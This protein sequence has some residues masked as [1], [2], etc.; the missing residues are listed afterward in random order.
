[1]I[2]KKIALFAF[3]FAALLAQITQAQTLVHYWNFN[4]NSSVGTLLTPN[5]TLVSGASIAAIPGGIS[6]IDLGGTGQGFSNENLNARNGDPAGTHLRFNDPIGGALEFC[7]P[8]TGFTNVV[9]KFST[10][11]SGSGAGLQYWHYST[12]GVNFEPFDTIAPNNGDPTLQ[13]LDFSEVA[14]VDDN[15]DFK[16]RV[17]FAQGGGGTVGNNRFDNFTLDA[18]Q[19]G[20]DVLPP[21]VAFFPLDNATLVP[22]N[23]NPTITFNEPVRLLNNTPLDNTNAASGISLRLDNESGA[24]VPFTTTVSGETITV[25]PDAALLNNQTYYLAVLE[26]TIED[27]NNNAITATQ[28]ITFTTIAQQTEF[29]AGDLVVVA[30]RTN[31]T[32]TEDQVALLTFVDILPGTLINFTD[33]KVTTNAQQ[34]CPGGL[35][36]ISPADACIPA[37]S[38]III[39]PDARNASVGTI[40]GSTFGLSS[41]GEQFIVYTGTAAAPDYITA[42]TTINWV[43]ANTNCGGSLSLIPAGLQDGLTSLNTSTAPGNTNGNSVNAFY[44]GAQT[45]NPATLRAMILDPANWV[46]VGAGTAPQV[47]PAWTF[48][49]PPNVL[50]ATVV[51][52]TTIQLIFNTDLELVSAAN[53]DNY[54]GIAGLQSAL[55]TG[56]NSPTDTITLTFD[57]GFVSGENY[58]L[59]VS[60]LESQGGLEMSC[61]FT[62]SFLYNTEIS[63]EENFI[64]IEENAG[65]LELQLNL[66]NPSNCSVMLEVLGAPFS[67]ADDADFTL[68]TQVLN[69]TGMSNSVQIV[70]IPV[71]DDMLEEQ[72]AEYFVLKL[73]DANGCTISGDAQVTIYIRDN[74]RQAAQPSKTVELIHVTSFDPSGAN[75]STTEVVAYDAGTQRLFTTSAITNVLDIVDF[76]NP[77]LPVNISSIDMTP[78]GGLTSVAVKNGL[79]AVASPNADVQSNGSVVFFDT[80]GNFL[81]QVTVGALPD[82]I[83]F[84][85]DNTKVITANEGEPNDAYTI[86]PEGSV[87]IIDLSGGINNL[88]QADVTTLLFTDFNANEAALIA[89]GVRKLKNTSTLSQDLEPE[90]ITIDADSKKAWVTL[91]ENNAVAEINLET[92]AIADL[93]PLGLKD[94]NTVGNGY[95][96]SDNNNEILIANWPI[97]AYFIPDAVA[98]YNVG[99]VN[100]LITANEGDEKELSGLNERTTVGAGSYMLDPTIFPQAEML[101]KSYN[102]GRMRVT[103]LHGDLDNDGDFDEIR[104]LGARSFSIFNAETRELVFDSGD[105]FE[106]YTAT[107]PSIS[108]LFNA[109]HESNTAKNRSRSKGPEPEGVAV[110]NFDGRTFAFIALERIG[111]VMAYEVTDPENAEFVDYINTRTLPVLGGDRGAE[112][113]TFVSGCDS[114]DGKPYLIVANEIS[115]TLSIFEISG[116][117]TAPVDTDSD[118]IADCHDNCPTA[119]NA[120]QADS[121]CDGVG[122]V[123]DVCDGGDDTIDNNGDGLP[124][125]RYYPGIANITDDWKCQ[126]DTRVQ[127]CYITV[128]GR[129]TICVNAS[130]VNTYLSR[131]GS[132]VGPCGEANC[133]QARPDF[134]GSKPAATAQETLTLSPNPVSDYLNIEVDQILIGQNVNLALRDQIGRMIW[135]MQFEN[136]ETNSIQL[137]VADLKIAAGMYFMSLQTD[138]GITT[139]PVVVSK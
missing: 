22:V 104:C 98:N 47:W 80:D 53:L 107:E 25:I 128:T 84:T 138:G 120:D 58:T 135:T 88:D 64:V 60:G 15:A 7:L 99:G 83:I 35:L 20:D 61:P 90:Y 125:C 52:N 33:A 74:D 31:A 13:V 3:A 16:L 82:M 103:N 70:N 126:N 97:K 4:D 112:S 127:V 115:G 94:V 93:W 109:D 131:R 111:G 6:A 73:S 57:P 85:P 101:K 69:F 81:K 29:E 76:S 91:Q 122:D 75:N 65:T 118:G 11:R 1:M 121:D 37:G 48:P 89:A 63:F 71:T 124:D 132:Y 49:G 77:A 44:N 67:T 8:T 19:S 23:V 21:T 95:D 116:S 123:C 62:F 96:V 18:D 87:S 72:H 36:W 46:A 30:Y 129:S 114:P 14:G 12:D 2:Q 56:L 38:V 66:E 106:L 108:P 139:K 100:Y 102:L 105:A 34:Q 79:V 24:A 17:T 59:T 43:L 40:S 26:N 133:A 51:N 55:Q 86:D 54:T 110:A 117:I 39:E 68:A 134:A 41:N 28:S 9:I 45:G 136:L 137:D 27:L 92:S 113:L 78:Y 10:R 42:L 130:S 119:A 50:E 32:G 5:V